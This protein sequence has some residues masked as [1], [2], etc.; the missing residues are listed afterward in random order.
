[1]SCNVYKTSLFSNVS[2]L[3][4][5]TSE[6]EITTD[7]MFPTL[8]LLSC[9]VICFFCFFFPLLSRLSLLIAPC[10][11]PPILACSRPRRVQSSTAW[12]TCRELVKRR[13]VWNHE[14]GNVEKHLPACLLDSRAP[15]HALS[16]SWNV[17]TG[18]QAATNENRKSLLKCVCSIFLF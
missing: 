2:F 11:I 12:G 18:C 16:R 14:K 7:F 4:N 8:S 5:A 6:I 3:W 13:W 10:R 15:W 1:M 17:G 9:W